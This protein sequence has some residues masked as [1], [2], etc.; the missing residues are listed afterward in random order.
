MS[1]TDEVNPLAPMETAPGGGTSGPL[2][3]SSVPYIL[4]S[5]V[6]FIVLTSSR[7]EILQAFPAFAYSTENKE[8]T[9]GGGKY[10]TVQACTGKDALLLATIAVRCG[11]G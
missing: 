7:Y 11:S 8:R 9:G 3:V 1:S 5:L 4:H 10:R 2:S 6:R